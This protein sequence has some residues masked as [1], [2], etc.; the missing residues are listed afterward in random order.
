M[1]C[2]VS[3]ALASVSVEPYALTKLKFQLLEAKV[4]V[5]SKIC[6]NDKI[7][8]AVELYREMI[9]AFSKSKLG[10]K[11]EGYRFK[12]LEVKANNAFK[13][14]S[15][16][17]QMIAATMLVEQGLMNSKTLELLKTFGR[18]VVKV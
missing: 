3:V 14:L 18:K 2:G 1:A 15:D 9:I 10:D 7:L 13:N 5:L 8:E 6:K 4:G 11:N 12:L 17:Q 16:D